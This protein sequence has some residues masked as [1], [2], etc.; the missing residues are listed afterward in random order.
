M[1]AGYSADKPVS[2]RQMVFGR[3][4]RDTLPQD[5]RPR[6][7]ATAHC[8]RI[9]GLLDDV[10]PRTSAICKRWYSFPGRGYKQQKHPPKQQ[11]TTSLSLCM[12]I[13]GV[14]RPSRRIRRSTKLNSASPPS[15]LCVLRFRATSTR[16]SESNA[17]CIL[18]SSS[19]KT[20]S[21]QPLP[22]RANSSR[23]ALPIAAPSMGKTCCQH[24]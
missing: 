11:H 22:F 20:C 2:R 3:I 4:E 13:A 24:R 14:H 19:G 7:G 18:G 17:S 1:F 12:P 23:S 15:S 6:H 10:M 5:V 8:P 21:E 16:P 9:I